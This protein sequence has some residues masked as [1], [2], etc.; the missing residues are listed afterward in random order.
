[1]SFASSRQAESDPSLRWDDGYRRRELARAVPFLSRGHGRSVWRAR[2]QR[3]IVYLDPPV[4]P[5]GSTRH[6]YARKLSSKSIYPNGRGGHAARKEVVRHRLGALDSQ[7]RILASVRMSRDINLRDA[8]IPDR[9]RGPFEN[10]HRFAYDK[11]VILPEQDHI[12]S[13]IA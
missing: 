11:G 7:R 9:L 5:L 3:K 12:R 10:S 8:T 1:M 6:R 4:L 13:L 2:R